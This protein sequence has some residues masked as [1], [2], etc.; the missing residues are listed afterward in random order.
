[1]KDDSNASVDAFILSNLPSTFGSLYRRAEQHGC[2][3]Y[4]PIDRRLQALRKKGVIVTVRE[5]GKYIWRA[6]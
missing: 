6:A 5:N 3:W 2:D 1:M 4:R